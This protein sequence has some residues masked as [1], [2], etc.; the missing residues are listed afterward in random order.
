MMSVFVRLPSTILSGCLKNRPD[1]ALRYS[2]QVG[3]KLRNIE[4]RL[5]NLLNKDVRTRLIHFLWQLVEQNLARIPRRDFACRIILH[6]G[7]SPA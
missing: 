1:L 2:K 5:I 7:I 3:A 4:N 6:T